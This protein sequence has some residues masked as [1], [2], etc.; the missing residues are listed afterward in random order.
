MTQS[1][2]ETY[3]SLV[4][5]GTLHK[6]AVQ[7]AAIQELQRLYDELLR[8]E[9]KPK[10]S[11]FERITGKNDDDEPSVP[12]GIYMHGGVGRGKVYVDGFIL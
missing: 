11:F 3:K 10:L 1:P 5:D 12:M 7:E 2:L 8:D 9:E 4:K 6:D